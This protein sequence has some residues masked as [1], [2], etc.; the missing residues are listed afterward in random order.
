MVECLLAVLLLQNTAPRPALT[1][2]L[3]R[4]QQHDRKGWTRIDAK[5]F[6]GAAKEFESAVQI[7]ADYGDA[8]H[9]LGKAYMAL[10]RYDAA[11][12]AFERCRDTYA[13]LGTQS[14]EHRLLANHAREDQIRMLQRR[15]SLLEGS[16]MSATAQGASG[17]PSPQMIDLKE[18]IRVLEGER[19]VG[20]IVGQPVAAPAY[21]LLALGSAYFRVD[22]VP[23][24]ERQF[25]LAL[26]AD[27]K[28]G[29]AHSNLA[30]VCLLT[31]RAAEAEQHVRLAEEARFQVNPELKRQ[32]RAALG[33]G[34]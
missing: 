27:P 16:P 4:A 34:S 3:Q 2:D 25:R 6:S 5:D 32:I 1:P 20:E 30:L 10:Q 17:A 12:R 7:Y 8:L 14:A 22:R 26:A 11:V 23:D 24:A 19:E 13:G 18:Q 9:G 15:L 33:S 28:F 21:I 31:G 29:E